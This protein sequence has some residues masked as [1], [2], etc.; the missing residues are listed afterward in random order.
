VIILCLILYAIIKANQN[1]LMQIFKHLEEQEK[2]KQIFDNL[3]ESII[4]IDDQNVELVNDK[5]KEDFNEHFNKCRM[6]E[7]EMN[8]AISHPRYRKPGI[9]K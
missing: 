7:E 5:F 8:D 9:I 4:V 3:E 2:L 1:T 6:S